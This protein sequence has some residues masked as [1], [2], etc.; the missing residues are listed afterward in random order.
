MVSFRPST[1]APPEKDDRPFAYDI[2]ETSQKQF[3]FLTLLPATTTSADIQR[4]ITTTMFT[5]GNFEALSY[6]WGQET[7]ICKTPMRLNGHPVYIR[8][9]LDAALRALRYTAKA[10]TL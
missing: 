10:R 8:N 3:R 2:L 6:V 5:G 7:D 4:I 1:P 9:N